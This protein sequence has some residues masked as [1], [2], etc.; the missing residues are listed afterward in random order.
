MVAPIKFDRGFV[1]TMKHVRELEEK[2]FRRKQIAPSLGL[3]TNA[4]SRGM[5]VY[6]TS[7]GETADAG[8]IEVKNKAIE[9]V[10]GLD[11][12]ECSLTYA[13]DEL[14]RT[15]RINGG[16][17]INRA[18]ASTNDPEKQLIG[19]QSA[20]GALE[21]MC[22]ALDRLPDVVHSSI[23]AEQRKDIETRLAEC[24][25]IIERRINI[26]RKDPNVDY[27]PQENPEAHDEA[28]LRGRPYR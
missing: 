25:R 6:L 27:R 21:G 17:P 12:G 28:D 18:T 5:R 15:I 20:V 3:S 23:T 10:K 7:L 1:A 24:R 4:I 11:T 19:Y 16:K 22:F 9:L 2:G 26:I 13:E 14:V 8:R